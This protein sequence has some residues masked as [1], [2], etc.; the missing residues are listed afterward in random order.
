MTKIQSGFTLIENM[1]VVAIISIFAAI[2]LPAY[3]DYTKRFHVA[4]SLTMTDRIRTAAVAHY[5]AK[6]VWPANNP[7][8][9]IA[10]GTHV[11]SE[12][13]KT[14]HTRN[15]VITIIFNEM[16]QNNKQLQLSAVASSSSIEWICRP[17]SNLQLVVDEKYL[18]ARC[19]S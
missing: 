10:S 16:V 13:I 12:A 11:T 14:V 17:S 7:D 18:P 19:R 15:G 8:A 4:E 9:G 1:I 3:Q 2:V 6:G 5:L